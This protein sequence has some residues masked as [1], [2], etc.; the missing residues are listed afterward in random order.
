MYTWWVNVLHSMRKPDGLLTGEWLLIQKTERSAL[1]VWQGG[2][3]WNRSAGKVVCFGFRSDHF[4][5]DFASR[6]SSSKCG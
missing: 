1:D 4:N 6:F 3:L 2:P 5:V